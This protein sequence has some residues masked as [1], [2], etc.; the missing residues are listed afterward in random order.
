MTEG[1]QD[2]VGLRIYHTVATGPKER[3]YS[4]WSGGKG[5]CQQARKDLSTLSLSS[6]QATPSSASP[7]D[8]QLPYGWH[9]L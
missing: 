1:L 3:D 9:A 5:K 2:G 7:L 8:Q 6:M 4:A